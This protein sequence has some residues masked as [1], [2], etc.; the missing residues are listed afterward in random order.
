MD[1]LPVSPV[2]RKVIVYPKT[3]FASMNLFLRS[4]WMELRRVSAVCLDV[5][6][7]CVLLADAALVPSSVFSSSAWLSANVPQRLDWTYL[8]IC[9]Q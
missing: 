7:R 3:T 9:S 4:G 8:V 2:L 1:V 6:A 5:R